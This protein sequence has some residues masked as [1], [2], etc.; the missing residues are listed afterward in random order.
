MSRS[1]FSVLA[2]LA[3]VTLIALPLTVS[4]Q[5]KTPITWLTLDWELEGV[6]AAFE[7]ANPDIDLQ[8]EQMTFNDLMQQIQVR[9][10]SGSTTPD[11]YSVDVPLTAS[12]GYRGWLMPLDDVFTEEEIADWLPSSVEAGTYEG[13]VLSAPVSTSTQLLYYNQEIFDRAGVTPP[14]P[15][16]RWTWEKIAEVAPQLTFDDNGDGTPE[17]WGF[18]WEQMPRIYQLQVLPASLGGDAIG[19]DGLT[20][21]GVINSPEWLEAFQYYYDIFNTLRVAPQGEVIW[22]PDIF[23]T[24]NIAMFVGGPWNIRRFAEAEVPFEWGVSRHPYFEEGEI[25]TPTGSWHVGVNPNTE[26]P[27]EARRFV[28]WLSTSEGGEMMWREGSGDFPAQQSV[29]EL[30]QTEAEFDEPPLSFLRIAADEATVNPVPRPTTVGF[31]EY[32]Q[33]LFDTFND[34]RNGVLPEEAL[35][36]AALRIESEMAKY[37]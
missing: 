10:G 32:E 13:Q 5:D 3:L 15:D 33:I 20:V 2:F 27:E 37:R 19:E 26:H 7:A 17:I 16:E 29:L 35:N 24:G 23:E 11:V 34:I 12:Y 28:H 21:E 1:R 22:P 36:T 4:A 18:V 6:E 9:L 30:F 25:V 14:G 8:I 31:L